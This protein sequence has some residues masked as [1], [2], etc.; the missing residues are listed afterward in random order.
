MDPTTPGG[1][2]RRPNP[3]WRAQN[4][5]RKPFEPVLWLAR[6]K[7]MTAVTANHKI[8]RELTMKSKFTV[9][10]LAALTIGATAVATTTD[11]QARGWGWRGVG[12]GLAAGA[13][14]GA[15][16]ASTVY[17]EPAYYGPRCRF[18]RNFDQ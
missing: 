14:I 18:V 12:L 2:I 8:A 3:L 4:P 6:P 9:A 1:H 16:A 13:I 11:A 15:A 10:L 7:L 5:T 17:A